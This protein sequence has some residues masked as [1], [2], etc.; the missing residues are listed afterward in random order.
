MKA[1]AHRSLIFAGLLLVLTWAAAPVRAQVRGAEPGSSGIRFL[2][3]G[4]ILS[5]SARAASEGIVVTLM[6]QEVATEFL[7]WLADADPSSYDSS[8]LVESVMF[9]ASPDG[10]LPMLEI[11][12]RTRGPVSFSVANE[13]SAVEVRLEPE[14]VD[15]SDSGGVGDLGDAG[16]DGTPLRRVL[17][18]EDLEPLAPEPSPVGTPNQDPSVRAR[19][20]GRV[21]LRPEPSL[22]ASPLMTL[23][24]QTVVR[25][26]DRTD[27]WWLVRLGE[28]EGWLR[29][30]LVEPAEP[31]ALTEPAAP[32]PA[33][34]AVTASPAEWLGERGAW[35][36][37]L[38]QALGAS[39]SPQWNGDLRSGGEVALQQRA[40]QEASRR[41][42][43]LAEQDLR[44]ARAESASLRI[45]LARAGQEIDEARTRMET[46]EARAAELEAVV[47]ALRREAIESRSGVE[48]E[49]LQV[50]E[51][52]RRAEVAEREQARLEERVTTLEEEL[53][54]SRVAAEMARVEADGLRLAARQAISAPDRL[55]ERSEVAELPERP[56]VIV[57]PSPEAL[58][59]PPLTTRTSEGG[60]L[61]AQSLWAGVEASLDG[62]LAAWSDQDPDGYF[63]FYADAF[64][65]ARDDEAWRELRSRRLREPEWIEVE[66][67]DLE[68]TLTAVPDEQDPIRVRASFVQSYRSSSY[69]DV[70][71]KEIDWSWVDGAWKIVDERSLAVLLVG[72]G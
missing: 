37:R 19:T 9:A 31:A 47:V 25:V 11:D 42:L 24:D 6:G 10:G 29:G 17:T 18:A 58:S 68:L 69:R 41:R 38:D 45:E 46:A 49:R 34:T 67:E 63:S 8:G 51:A 43:A 16:A 56:T 3:D 39:E 26:L 13:G 71:R 54:S 53:I 65:A 15:A 50:F 23:P 61:A 35:L 60:T 72:R 52:E 30:D 4:S 55:G 59:N 36:D 57:V 20:I 70:V 21:N 48:S 44:E 40:E 66:I 62:W 7:E 22:E 2:A 5:V 12:V 33:V 27:D 14:Q 28:L 1:K 64:L 32:R